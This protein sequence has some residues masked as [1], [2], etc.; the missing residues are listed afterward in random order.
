MKDVRI[1]NSK[2]MLLALGFILAMLLAAIPMLPTKAVSTCT[3]T[4]GAATNNFSDSDNWTGCDGAGVPDGDDY[5]VLPATVDSDRTLINDIVGLTVTGITVTGTYIEDEHGLY[6]INGNDFSISGDI[7]GNG[8]SNNNIHIYVDVDITVTAN[9]VNLGP[10]QSSGS[11]SIGANNVSIVG[12]SYF[13]QNLSGSGNVTFTNLWPLVGGAG[14]CGSNPTPQPMPIMGSSAGFSGGVIINENR[15]IRVT[16]R[17]GDLGHSASSITLNGGA[18]NFNMDHGSNMNF[19]TPMTLNDGR[20]YVEQGHDTDCFA[21]NGSPVRTV[22]I[23][24]NV[25][26]TSPT[27]VYLYGAASINFSG[28]VTGASNIQIA[29]GLNTTGTLTV[30]GVVK[31]S[32]VRVTTINESNKNTYCDDDH[33]LV[34]GVSVNNKI[35][36]NVDCSGDGTPTHSIYGI[37]GGTGSLANVTF[38]EG[39]MLAPGL[40][41]GCLSFTSLTMEAGSTYEVEINGETACSG[42]DQAQVSGAVDVTDAILDVQ[43]LSSYSPTNGTQFIIIDNDGTDAVTGAF[44]GMPNGSTF[45]VDGVTYRINYDGGDGN[46]VVLTVIDSTVGDPDTGLPTLK[47]SLIVSLLTTILAASLLGGSAYI[48]KRR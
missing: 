3:W 4:G 11:L 46:D 15:S 21:P 6:R 34:Y 42:Y 2:P 24:G 12:F 17:A 44:E 26:A 1:I 18:L 16:S 43:R 29:S 28:S 35:V 20:I 7:V 23:T 19:S 5:I 37:L 31:T 36:V 40:S 39:S 38:R 30:G 32:P 47:N 8:S 14:G 33:G 41:P 10:I 22:N 9:N 27:E 13:E 45:T 48:A 25:N